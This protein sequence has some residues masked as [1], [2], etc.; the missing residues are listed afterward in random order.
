MNRSLAAA[1][2]AVVLMVPTVA[3]PEWI[4]MTS[5][6]FE[7]YTTSGERDG[8]QTLVLFE[9][10]RDFFMRIKS[11]SVTTRLPVTIVGF[12]NAKEFRP[13]Q[14]SEAAAAYYTGDE[15]HDYIVMSDLGAEQTPTAIHEY[16][17]LLV[18]HSGLKMPIWLNEGFAEVY[19]TLK[20]TSGQILMGTVPQGRAIALTQNK[21]LPLER[22]LAIKHDSPEYNEK[23]RAGVFYAESWLLAHMLMLGKDYKD[24]FSKFV[25][26]LHESESA[27]KAFAAAYKKKLWEVEL[28]L[29]KYYSANSVTAILFKT[30]F[31]KIQI[32]PAQ[33]AS[34]VEV[35]ITL[36]KLVF[37]L[38]RYD[39]ATERFSRLAKAHS[40]S[41]EIEEALAYLS[42]QRDDRDKALTHFAKAIDLGA[43]DW[44]TLWDY[45]RLL[46]PQQDS[47]AYLAA[48]RKT[49]EVK[50]DL[51]DARLAL[52]SELARQRSWA[53]A[54]ICLREVKHIE[55]ERAPELFL[56]LAYSAM[57]LGRNDEAKG[58]AADARKY[59]RDDRQRQ[60]ADR[61]TAY[62]ER[63]PEAAPP[64]TA[65]V[66]AEAGSPLIARR[67]GVEQPP[68]ETHP[69]GPKTMTIK[70]NFKR[71]DCL[72]GMARMHV[73]DSRDTYVLLIRDPGR[74]VL[75]GAANGPVELKCGPQNAAVAV[76]FVPEKN[77]QHGTVGEVREVEMIE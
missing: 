72:E 2:M 36:A 69:A 8:R 76:T 16:M 64:D 67:E 39:E 75:R 1:T 48:L 5:P 7:L 74:I 40:N 55:P 29:H 44:K 54:L 46:G 10:V 37:L 42:W 63:R 71:L 13:Y 57:N 9:Q 59:A 58:F 51:V 70:G 68:V 3:A 65:A 60:D 12:R 32:E 43:K 41:A 56:L 35:E 27:E 45:A 6:N 23:D 52:G 77:E 20:P 19:S 11:Q 30:R 15:Q 47:Q 17:H 21:W 22:V 31:E 14:V 50:P 62:L 33:P 4:K 24:G 53:Q 49:L 66:V 34:E 73:M 38:R 26:V 28:D 18:R 61:L 25:A